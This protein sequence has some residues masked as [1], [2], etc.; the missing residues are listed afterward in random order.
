LRGGWGGIFAA[1]YG[2]TLACHG[3]ESSTRAGQE[4]GACYN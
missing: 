3:E 1:I 4:R 2:G